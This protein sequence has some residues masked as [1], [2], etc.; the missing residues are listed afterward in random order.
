M[1]SIIMQIGHHGDEGCPDRAK[2]NAVVNHRDMK[3]VFQY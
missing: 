1:H 2:S 3:S